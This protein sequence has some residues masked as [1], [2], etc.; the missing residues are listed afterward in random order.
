MRYLATIVR[1]Q[2]FGTQQLQLHSKE[3]DKYCWIPVGEE[4]VT[5]LANQFKPGT[6]VIA[7]LTATNQRIQRIEEATKPM[8]ATIHGFTNFTRRHKDLVNDFEAWKQSMAMQI[9][10]LH[11]REEELMGRAQELNLE[12][13][14]NLACSL[15]E[16]QTSTA[17][18]LY[19]TENG[20]SI[21]SFS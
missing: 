12:L 15:A 19:E 2:M 3:I 7:H 10:E 8:V 16:H 6:L 14:C 4:I 9:Q 13:T 21:D 17:L 11:R 20:Y 18:E 5:E 1:K